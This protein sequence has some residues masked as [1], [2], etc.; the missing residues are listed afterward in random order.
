ME[1]LEATIQCSNRNCQASNPQENKFC[2]NCGIPLVKRY[3]WVLGDWSQSY[4]VGQLIDERYLLKAPKIVLDTQPGVPPKLTEEVPSQLRPY[5][6]LFPYRLHLPQIYS[7]Y[8]SSKENG[9]ESEICLLEYSNIPLNT[10][11]DLLYPNLL[12]T[13]TE[14]WAQTSPLRQ[15]NWLWQ[16]AKLWH[17]LEQQQM[18]SSLVDNP[19]LIRVNGPVLHLLELTK[20][21][22]HY[23]SLK[24]LGQFWSSLVETASPLMANFL[25]ELCNRLHKG[26]IPHTEYLFSYLDPAIA[27]CAQWHHFHYQIFT[28]THSGPTRDHNEDDC[29][30]PPEE[31][32][33]TEKEG[34]MPFALVC[35]G[36]GGQEGGEIAS[37]LA[38]NTLLENMG[39]L[40]WL[41]QGSN[42]EQ[43]LEQLRELICLSNDRISQRND[44]EH[45]QERQRMG[46]T[47]VMALAH[48]HEVYLGN[49]GDS[50][51]YQITPTTCHQVTV[52]DDLA[53]RE[54]TLSYLFYRDAIQYPNSGALVQALG[55]SESSSLHPNLDRLL[56]DDSCVLLLCSDGLSDY[57]RVEQY[58]DSEIAPILGG[59]RDIATVGKNLIKL[60]N[61][62]NGHDN[63]TIAL[64]YC[65]VNLI[66]DPNRQPLSIDAIEASLSTILRSQVSQKPDQD[67]LT[68]RPDTEP[69][70]SPKVTIPPTPTP[71]PT[72]ASAAKTPSSPKI[73]VWVIGL[74]SLVAIAGTAYFI[75]QSQNQPQQETIETIP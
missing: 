36:I 58:W 2:Q 73:W 7:Y 54:A 51:I 47:I 1:N 28:S 60:A 63:V 67:T 11:G 33:D 3:L 46:T 42:Y 57:D 62:K 5:L 52:D 4:Q 56:V 30:P 37:E 35:D 55:M 71:T 34:I 39:R 25:E 15:L 69:N 40:A 23:Y 31:L 53:T 13:L 8:P 41:G 17:P 26:R 10:D 38:K 75:W 61:T 70:P 74:L 29:Y 20:D 48:G 64:V 6:K 22:H 27:Q 59:E 18:V 32:I 68:Q 9:Q 16:M 21:T 45:R 65:Q 72:V 66:E 50:R 19:N 12:P 43:Y 49:V 14:V 44:A 24:Q